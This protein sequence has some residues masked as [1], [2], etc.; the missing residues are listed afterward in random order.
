MRRVIIESPYAG[1][2]E[3]ID[4]NVRY[5]RAACADCFARGEAPWASHLLYT[6]PGIWRDEIEEERALGIEAGLVWGTAAAATVVYL[7]LGL[8]RGM[9]IG[10]RRARHD[11]RTV[12][13]RLLPPDALHAAIGL[14]A[15]E[16]SFAD[17]TRG[18]VRAQR[19]L[20]EIT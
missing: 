4:R 3:I 17:R 19:L 5:A 7:D 12:D 20:E 11:R 10:I 14:R 16:D 18:W 9:E 15:V 2:L 13:L 6:Q 1:T 8:S